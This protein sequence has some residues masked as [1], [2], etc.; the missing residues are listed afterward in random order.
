MVLEDD[1]P[2][3]DQTV[4]TKTNRWVYAGVAVNVGAFLILAVLATRAKVIHLQHDEDWYQATAHTFLA[5][6]L[7]VKFLREYPGGA[8]PLYPFVHALFAPLT[9]LALPG[10]RLLNMVLFLLTVGAVAGLFRVQKIG[11]PLASSWHMMAAPMMYGSV[12]GALTDIPALLFFSAHLPLLLLAVSAA[13]EAGSSARAKSYGLAILAGLCYGLAILGRQQNLAALAAVP[14]LG[15]GARA[16]WPV[17]AAFVVAAL[18]MPVP[19]FVI[20]GGLLPPIAQY[21]GKGIS[22]TYGMLSFAYA[23]AVYSIYDP[24]FFLRLRGLAIIA[25]S[26]VVHL[27]LNIAEVEPSSTGAMRI[28]P[29]WLVPYFIPVTCGFLV[30]LGICFLIELGETAWEFRRD[31]AKLFLVAVAF[32]LLL[33]PLKINHLF[34][35]RY[36]IPALP[37]ILLMAERR[38]PDTPWKVVRMAVACAMGLGAFL[39]RIGVG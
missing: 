39:P 25:A 23:G 29:G 37:L 36:V 10:I 18:A 26:I 15:L 19:V 6:G 33:T 30:G 24:R 28:L 27:A 35:S 5:E 4:A 22:I 34:S 16:V 2:A 3:P 31:R 38:C 14:L 8:G 1:A 7:T 21:A 32:L 9:G 11:H 13:G 17:L 12:G 20:W